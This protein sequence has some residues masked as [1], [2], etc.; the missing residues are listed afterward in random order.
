[1]KTKLYAGLNR[2]RFERISTNIPCG[3]FDVY[4]SENINNA[5][6]LDFSAGGIGIGTTSRLEVGIELMVVINSFGENFN[7]KA[8]IIHKKLIMNDIFVYGTRF[9]HSGIFK[10]FGFKR[11]L[12]RITLQNDL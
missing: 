10:R 6:I 7:M 8:E 4:T 11:K 12:K 5:Y 1:M 3:L 9:K 2:R